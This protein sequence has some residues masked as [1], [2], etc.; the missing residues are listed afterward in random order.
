MPKELENHPKIQQQGW[1]TSK[2]G[3]ALKILGAW[4]QNY[5]EK[6]TVPK[7]GGKTASHLTPRHAPGWTHHR[8]EDRSTA[9]LVN[10]EDT[11][12]SLAD[13]GD[14]REQ[15][16]TRYSWFHLTLRRYTGF[17][18]KDVRLLK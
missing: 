8:S 5:C 17:P 11:R 18:I 10:S 16:K 9:S 6:G 3:D 13:L 4:R 12:L 14:V 7:V 1:G 2:L 15:L